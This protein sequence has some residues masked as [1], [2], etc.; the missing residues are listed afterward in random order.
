MHR[1]SRKHQEQLGSRGQCLVARAED[2]IPNLLR[3]RRAAGLAGH[4][5]I[6]AAIREM[7]GKPCNLRGFPDALDPLDGQKASSGF[8]HRADSDAA[9]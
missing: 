9:R 3:E 5:V 4:D 2:E 7:A 6:D 8:R 1:A